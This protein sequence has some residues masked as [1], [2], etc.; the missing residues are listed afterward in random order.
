MSVDNGQYN[1]LKPYNMVLGPSIRRIVDLSDLSSV[2]SITPTG[3]S[4]SPFSEHFGDQT[5]MWL[6]GQY[7]IFYQDSLLFKQ[8]DV[9]TM[10]LVPLK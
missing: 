9:R 8:S 10:K 2:Q 4:G 5:E 1:W 7:R 3:Q 6:N